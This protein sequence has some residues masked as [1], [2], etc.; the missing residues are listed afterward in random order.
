[1]ETFIGAAPLGTVFLLGPGRH[2]PVGGDPIRGRQPCSPTESTAG[3]YLAFS[4]HKI[5]MRLPLEPLHITGQPNA[6]FP[7]PRRPPVQQPNRPTQ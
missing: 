7:P 3:R 4:R 6:L 1:R 2:L 5:L